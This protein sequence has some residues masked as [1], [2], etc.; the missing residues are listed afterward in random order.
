[1]ATITLNLRYEGPTAMVGAR[2]RIPKVVKDLMQP[3]EKI[4]PFLEDSMIDLGENAADH[5]KEIMRKKIPRKSPGKGFRRV[6]EGGARPDNDPQ[7]HLIGLIKPEHQIGNKWIKIGIARRSELDTM[8]AQWSGGN[9]TVS[10]YPYWQYV[11]YGC[12][13]ITGYRFLP[14][15]K[16]KK[17][18]YREGKY[19]KYG[20]G[21]M[22][23]D[24]EGSH[25]GFPAVRM[26]FRT[27]AYIRKRAPI[28]LRKAA[29]AFKK[30]LKRRK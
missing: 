1:M 7:N 4:L 18:K 25:P 10:A 12:P 11:E 17:K 21:V 29:R 22:I 20:E 28:E 14:V 27:N 23:K 15:K 6:Q 9:R 5:C 24:L 3:K 2:Y 8:G 19:G 16:I 30:W 26:F 13:K